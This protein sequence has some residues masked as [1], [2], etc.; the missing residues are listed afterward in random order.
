M[1]SL[2]LRPPRLHRGDRL[3]LVA[4]AGRFSSKVLER[5]TS[6]FSSSGLTLELPAPLL[7]RHPLFAAEDTHRL[8]AMQ[9]ALDSTDYRGIL[10]V[11]GGYGTSRILPGLSLD[12][13]ARHPKV[14]IGF[15]DLTVLHLFLARKLDLIS[16]HGPMLLSGFRNY[17]HNALKTFTNFFLQQNQGDLLLP[18]GTSTV[19]LRRGEAEGRLV[20]GNLTMLAHS[21]G[22]PFEVD[23]VGRILFLEDINEPLYK[24]DRSLTQLAL[25]GKLYSVAAVILGIFLD[26]DMPIA[27]KKVGASV[28]EKLPSGVPVVADFPIS[29]GPENCYLPHNARACLRKTRPDLVLPEPCFEN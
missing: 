17:R 6:N 15:S 9:T 28:L 27:R 29:H 8:M 7:R 25:A 13:L 24:I 20:G 22:T 2:P 4:P 12:S 23:T 21:L 19:F 16:F 1:T 26:R 11:R 14:I 18:Q 5:A 3:A 10:A